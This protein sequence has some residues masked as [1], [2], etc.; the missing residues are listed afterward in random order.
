[1]KNILLILTAALFWTLPVNAQNSPATID[2]LSYALG[3]NIGLSLKTFPAKLDAVSLS[4]AITDAL[5]DNPDMTMQESEM[6]LQNYFMR[7]QNEAASRNKKEGKA[8]LNANKDKPGVVVSPSG[9][10]YKIERAGTGISPTEDDEVEVHYRGTLIDG[11]EFDSSYKRGETITFALK[12]VIKG[13]TEGLQYAKEGGKIWL[14][15]PS[16]L[17]YGD[18]SRQSSIIEGGSTLIFEIELIRV[19]KK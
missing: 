1:M 12:S 14:Y 18:V 17:A 6:F 3:T 2:S 19:I 16:D 8:F 7:Q 5:N 13:W 9:L 4:K 11:R 10:Q 15:I